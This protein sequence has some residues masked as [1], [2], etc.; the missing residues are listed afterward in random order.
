MILW[1]IYSYVYGVSADGAQWTLS[2]QGTLPLIQMDVVPYRQTRPIKS[3][4]FHHEVHEGH[5]ERIDL[6]VR[7][8]ALRALRGE[9][10][11]PPGGSRGPVKKFFPWGG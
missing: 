4:L 6:F 5:E 11:P 9:S 10:R 2:A 7:L 3:E 8:R 1:R